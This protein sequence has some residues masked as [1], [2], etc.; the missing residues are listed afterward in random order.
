MDLNVEVK[1]FCENSKK[2]FRGG[3]GGQ[4]RVGVRGP[5][6]GGGGRLGSKVWGRWMMWGMGDVNQEMKGIAK[7]SCKYF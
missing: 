5:I 4:G 2:K 1:C 3:G 7:I 6:R